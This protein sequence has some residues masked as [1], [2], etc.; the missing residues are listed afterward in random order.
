M[1]KNSKKNSTVQVI[2]PH[3]NTKKRRG[4]ETL[5]PLWCH[6]PRHA[7][8]SA[9]HS[10]R[11]S[12][13][14]GTHFCRCCIKS[15]TNEVKAPTS[16]QQSFLGNPAPCDSPYRYHICFILF[17]DTIITCGSNICDRAFRWRR[18]ITT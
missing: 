5:F 7:A 8:Y 13:Y 14:C 4:K 1:K 2:S 18:V 16:K 9:L 17:I 10:V 6:C 15:P 3:P 12:N 11:N